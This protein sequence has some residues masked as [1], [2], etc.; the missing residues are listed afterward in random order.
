MS[1]P[2]HLATRRPV[3]K[4][5]QG[6]LVCLPSFLPR[7]PAT[8]LIGITLYRWAE[9]LRNS[10]NSTVSKFFRVEGQLPKESSGMPS[11]EVHCFLRCLTFSKPCVHLDC[12]SAKASHHY[13]GVT[14]E[15]V[16]Y[17]GRNQRRVWPVWLPPVVS[18]SLFNGNG[19][20][21]TLCISFFLPSSKSSDNERNWW[22]TS[23]KTYLTGASQHL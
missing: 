5:Y 2:S 3:H 13:L 14:L 22:A 4:E 18:V 15:E 11:G 20:R 8:Q 23:S 9:P 19:R 21:Y 10:R 17:P 7:C 16:S 12:F 6:F 1:T